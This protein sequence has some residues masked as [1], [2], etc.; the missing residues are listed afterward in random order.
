MKHTCLCIRLASLDE[1]PNIFRIHPELCS[2]LSAAHQTCDQDVRK[3]APITEMVWQATF[4][5]LHNWPG[6]PGWQ[7]R[8]VQHDAFALQN[9]IIVSGP[10][11]K[12]THWISC[13]W[14]IALRAFLSAALCAV[15][16]TECPGHP[17]AWRLTA[18][19]RSI[20]YGWCPCC[21]LIYS[22]PTLSY[23]HIL[24]CIPL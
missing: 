16:E 3:A 2:V 14:S 13:L 20:L 1:V 24:A 17:E 23:L 19:M 11:W 12:R 22:N 8:R 9:S 6:C 18:A 7:A 5:L 10:Q 4:Q 15:P 21:K